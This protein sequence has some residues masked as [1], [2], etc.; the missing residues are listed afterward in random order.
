[1][2][3]GLTPEQIAEKQVNRTAG[4][5]ADVRRGVEAV[6]ESPTA[7]AARNLAKAKLN[8][9][10]AIDSGRTA[11]ALNGVS[12]QDWQSKTIAKADRIPQGVTE[13]MPTIIKFHQQ[14]AS[15]QMGID[16]KLASMSTM[17]GADMEARVLTQIRAMREFRFKRNA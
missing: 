9:I 6:T 1:M 13:A 3:R 16:R 2:A 15:F 5:V 4:A 14:R 12:L 11:E 10:A 7:K 17:T 8:Y